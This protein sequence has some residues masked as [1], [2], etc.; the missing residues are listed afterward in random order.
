[1]TKQEKLKPMLLEGVK[2]L[3]KLIELNAPGVIIG[4]AAWHAFATTLAVYGDGAA[5]T[6]VQ[7]IR[8]GNLHARAVCSHGDC[9]EYVDRP[10]L[11]ICAAHLKELGIQDCE[12]TQ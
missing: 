9:T 6:M 12:V 4:A 1:M 3:L 8:E 7:D 2:R 5:S 11:G 10:D